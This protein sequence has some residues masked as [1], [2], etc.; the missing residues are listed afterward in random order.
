MLK[1][2]GRL[3]PMPESATITPIQGFQR[4]CRL[5]FEAYPVIPWVRGSIVTA[6]T[7]L[8]AAQYGFIQSW[9]QVVYPL[10]A[11]LIIYVGVFLWRLVSA[12]PATLLL[13]IS[14]L[15]EELSAGLTGQIDEWA[16][17]ERISMEDRDAMLDLD[18]AVHLN[19]WVAR[20]SAKITRWR[21]LTTP[22]K[23]TYDLPVARCFVDRQRIRAVDLT[24]RR[25]T[26]TESLTALPDFV[27]HRGGT[28]WLRALIVGWE[29]ETDIQEVTV[30]AEIRGE[31]R[32]IATAGLA[33]LPVCLTLHDAGGS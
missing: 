4:A 33:D 14:K 28:G 19:L 12:T 20:G 23:V 5:T 15:E 2:Y 22:T 8:L 30:E 1:R 6:V 25:D 27:D 11:A 29:E 13:K 10:G 17:F 7:M 16:S 9:S 32:P 3:A 26:I 24:S 21:L 31:W 18:V